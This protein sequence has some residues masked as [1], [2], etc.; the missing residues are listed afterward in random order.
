[1]TQDG[2][3]IYETW[4]AKSGYEAGAGGFAEAVSDEKVVFENYGHGDR[5]KLWV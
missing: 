2:W 3:W 4:D 5:G 1:M